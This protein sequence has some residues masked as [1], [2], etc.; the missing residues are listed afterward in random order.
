MSSWGRCQDALSDL[1]EYDEGPG[2]NGSHMGPVKAAG[3][4]YAQWHAVMEHIIEAV[5]P[6][7]HA[8]GRASAG[9]GDEGTQP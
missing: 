4:T 2:G 8:Q 7:A 3:I 9:A 6:I 5:Y 1:Y